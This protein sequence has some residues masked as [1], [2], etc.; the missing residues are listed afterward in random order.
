MGTRTRAAGANF[1]LP[2]LIM[3]KVK[4]KGRVTE[5]NGAYVPGRSFVGR[6]TDGQERHAIWRANVDMP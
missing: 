3:E 5:T 2:N 4:K 6:R 1:H